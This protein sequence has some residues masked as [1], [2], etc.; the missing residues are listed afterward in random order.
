[1]KT[2]IEEFLTTFSGF[3]Q[4]VFSFLTTYS[5]QQLFHSSQPTTTFFTATAQ[6]N[7]PKMSLAN[8]L[9]PGLSGK[10]C[11]RP[12]RACQLAPSPCRSETQRRDCLRTYKIY[13]I[14]CL[15]SLRCS[16]TFLAKELTEKKD[17]RRRHCRLGSVMVNHHVRTRTTPTRASTSS[18]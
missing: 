13:P 14:P 7:R 18:T 6:P 8:P 3:H 2:Y 1:V 4:T 10:A 11:Q 17:L 9:I 16:V 12:L 5:L 15:P